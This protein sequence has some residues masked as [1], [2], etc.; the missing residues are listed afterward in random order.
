MEHL[1]KY[2]AL[3]HF[4]F[5]ADPPYMTLTHHYNSI[6]SMLSACW[7]HGEF[8][9]GNTGRWI[10]VGLMLG[11]RRRR[12]ANIKTI[13]AQRLVFV[14]RALRRYIFFIYTRRI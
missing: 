7:D 2:R 13:L 1:G 5:N 10:N 9:L 14:D 12:W 11:Q 6:G 4:W 3:K 8:I